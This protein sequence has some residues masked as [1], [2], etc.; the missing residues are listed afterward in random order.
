MVDEKIKKLAKDVRK[1]YPDVKIYL[2]GSRARDDW[3]KNS[4]Y[5]LVL[6][7]KHFDKIKFFD[8]PKKIYDLW[9]YE[10]DIEPIA[11]SP[12]EFENA[13][14]YSTIIRDAMKY[15]VEL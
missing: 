8:R 15:W 13:K 3:M 9:Q 4:D 1:I 2:F 11:Y 6:I 14:K 5:D 7:S 12:L 10:Q